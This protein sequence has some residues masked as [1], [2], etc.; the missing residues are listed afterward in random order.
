[1]YSDDMKRTI[2]QGVI[3]RLSQLEALGVSTVT[4]E[5]S[6][7][8][9]EGCID[10]VETFNLEGAE[11]ALPD[12]VFGEL[13]DLCMQLLFTAVGVWYDGS[14]GHGIMLI[15]VP[16]GDVKVDHAWYETIS[17]PDARTFNLLK[18]AAQ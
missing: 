6:G 2:W 15:T 14:G 11:V 16:T 4:A 9:D 12:D 1:M 13:P 7:T 3:G 18:K 5:Y 8:G 10:K 17:V